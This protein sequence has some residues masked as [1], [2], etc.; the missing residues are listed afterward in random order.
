[1]IGTG[2][3]ESAVVAAPSCPHESSPQQET[4]PAPSSAQLC[5]T[6]TLTAFAVEEVSAETTLGDANSGL[7]TSF[8]SEYALPQQYTVASVPNAQLWPGKPPLS[9]SRADSP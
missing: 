2:M 6:P 3:D 7:L 9:M 1:M 8:G 4:A 5:S